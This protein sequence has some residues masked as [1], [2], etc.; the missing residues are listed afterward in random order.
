MKNNL[1]S[2]ILIVFGWFSLTVV[3]HASEPKELA[4]FSE[5]EV[6]APAT[7]LEEDA[8]ETPQT[9]ALEP[10][11][12][13]EIEFSPKEKEGRGETS[14][15][16]FTIEETTSIEEEEAPSAPSKDDN[17]TSSVEGILGILEGSNVNVLFGYSAWLNQWQLS[18]YPRDGYSQYRTALTS[19]PELVSMLSLTLKTG[20]FSL[21]GSF[22]PKQTFQFSDVKIPYPWKNEGSEIFSADM[23]YMDVLAER[24][25]WSLTANYEIIRSE[26]GGGLSIGGGIKKVE[27]EYEF[28]YIDS[29]YSDY[30]YAVRENVT[31]S[32]PSLNIGGSV[33]LLYDSYGVL[34]LYGSFAYGAFKTK[35]NN[36][37]S[38]SYTPYY[39]AEIGLSYSLPLKEKTGFLYSATTTV[40]YRTQSF[41]Q[42]SSSDLI[43][44]KA[45][46]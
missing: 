15:K 26:G 21:S 5:Q 32:G 12:T 8:L 35:D 34:G 29:T 41:Y 19:D 37:E 7:T 9:E 43:L 17:G 28:N 27:F 31:M 24:R 39:L 20:K 14:V 10:F 36:T 25:E 33:P 38:N 40:G 4:P 45:S 22:I 3:V 13:R 6:Q 23:V 30:T 46:R 11:S 16:P 18:L 2:F 1:L 44:P 42:E